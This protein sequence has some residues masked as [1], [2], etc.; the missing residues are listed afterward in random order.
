[1]DGVADPGEATFYSAADQILKKPAK[2]QGTLDARK[3]AETVGHDSDSHVPV[4]SSKNVTNYKI[5]SR[6]GKPVSGRSVGKAT[7]ELKASDIPIQNAA[8]K[9]QLD[10]LVR[11][12]AALMAAQSNRSKK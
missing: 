7:I 5:V 12:R 3:A 11:E 10:R 9:E 4:Q 6:G 1:M 8:K 2:R